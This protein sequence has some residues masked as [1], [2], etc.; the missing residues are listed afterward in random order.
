MLEAWWPG[1]RPIKHQHIVVA[2]IYDDDVILG[3]VSNN[4][5]ANSAEVG[6]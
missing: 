2:G 6:E 3:H 5:F 4:V 1:C